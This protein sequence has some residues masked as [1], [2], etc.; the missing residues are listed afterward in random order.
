MHP[1]A[2]LPSI[3]PCKYLMLFS[4]YGGSRI[5]TTCT[6][7]RGGFDL[8]RGP[9]PVTDVELAQPIR[10]SK[11]IIRTS[12]FSTELRDP[13]VATEVELAQSIRLSKLLIRPSF[14]HRSEF[15]LVR[16]PLPVTEVELAQLIRLSKGPTSCHRGGASAAD[17]S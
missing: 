14:F 17:S 4:S 16:G 3:R 13:V 12:F 1:F 11:L 6:V 8:V 5:Q 15:D 2:S 9:V 7:K 10:L